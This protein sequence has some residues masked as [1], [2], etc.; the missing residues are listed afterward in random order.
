MLAFIG[1]AAG[2]TAAVFMFLLGKL[3]FGALFMGGAFSIV[4]F[5]KELVVLA[6]LLLTVHFSWKWSLEIERYGN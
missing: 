6:F 2:F 1:V 3:I 5:A 4:L